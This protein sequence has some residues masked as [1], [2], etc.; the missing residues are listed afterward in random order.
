MA[1]LPLLSSTSINL[2]MSSSSSPPPPSPPPPPRF[3]VAFPVTN[4]PINPT[5][6]SMAATINGVMPLT[7]ARVREHPR[8][9]NNAQ[10]CRYPFMAASNSC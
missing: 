2:N 4:T 3:P 5:A 7:S 6:P 8:R 1:V 10:I 9:I